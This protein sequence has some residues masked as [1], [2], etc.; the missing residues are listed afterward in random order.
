M[1]VCGKTPQFCCISTEFVTCRK[2]QKQ[3]TA[4]VAYAADDVAPFGC[5]PRE[6][7]VY[8]RRGAKGPLCHAGD[9]RRKVCATPETFKDSATQL[10]R[11]AG[12]PGATP[13][14]PPHRRRP[15]R[16][17]PRRAVPHLRLA[18]HGL[19]H[20]GVAPRLTPYLSSTSPVQAA[21]HPP[22][23]EKAVAA[24]RKGRAR[25]PERISRW[26]KSPDS[27][28]N[29]AAN[30]PD[31]ARRRGGWYGRCACGGPWAPR[32]GMDGILAFHERHPD[33]GP[34]AAGRPA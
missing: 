7:F 12:H 28:R 13:A 10:Q 22:H 20:G 32:G 23:G 17:S 11:R 6:H 8:T 16:G 19:I 18:R 2:G 30:P 9:T 4:T 34:R 26:R 27:G 14:R 15:G 5:A 3:Q 25:A 1:Q 31:G 24:G 29:A 33:D 21:R